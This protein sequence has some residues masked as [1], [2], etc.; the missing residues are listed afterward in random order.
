M[1]FQ[2]Y[3]REAFRHYADFAEAVLLIL[4]AAIRAI[5]GLH[6]PQTMSRA[7]DPS[8][9]KNK[10]IARGIADTNELEHQIKDLAGCRLIFYT[11][12]DVLKLRSSRLIRDNFEVID[13]KIHHPGP[14]S[15]DELYIADH[16]LVQ[17]RTERLALPEY[18]RFAG[19]R[20]EV[21][22]QTILNHAWAEM[23]HDRIYKK[24]AFGS[25][26]ASAFENIKGRMQEVM[27]RYLLPAGYEFENIVR[28]YD[29]LLAGKQ[30]FDQGAI[31]AVVESADNNARAEALDRL[32]NYVLPHYDDVRSEYPNIT[33]RL[34]QVFS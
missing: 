24:P 12:E 25:F 1:D 2:T 17:L 8:S 19:M 26:G 10:L 4:K 15:Q 28:N 34:V 30:L 23:A 13:T 20:C 22:I 14:D 18:A 29:R 21:Q 31:D 7:K 6:P 11:N 5:Q 33:R 27:R 9:L 32:A 16:Y 3:E